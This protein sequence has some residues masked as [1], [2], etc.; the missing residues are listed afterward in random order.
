MGA[1]SNTPQA[2]LACSAS[3][4][5]QSLCARYNRPNETSADLTASKKF[6]HI[7]VESLRNK[8]EHCDIEIFKAHIAGSEAPQLTLEELT[9]HKA[10]REAE[11][12]EAERLSAEAERIAAEAKAKKDALDFAR[13]KR[14]AAE[15]KKKDAHAEARYAD[16][17]M[18]EHIQCRGN[19]T[20]RRREPSK[21][22]IAGT[23][24]R[25]LSTGGLAS[26]GHRTWHSPP[27]A[28]FMVCR[29]RMALNQ[30]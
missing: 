11:D 28:A 23:G 18:T 19:T 10:E 20:H 22:E 9:A 16:T 2:A 8:L 14:L 21:P 25:F 1:T 29:R 17:P 30:R 7:T 3:R 13:R 5:G 24:L 26:E 4:I 6:Y 15:Q 12:A 27:A